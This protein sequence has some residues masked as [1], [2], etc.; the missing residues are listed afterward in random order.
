METHIKVISW[1]YIILGA[2]GLLGAAILILLVA[3]GGLISGDRT[4]ILATT[5]VS[6][7][8]GTVIILVSVPGIIAGIGLLKYRPWARILALVLGILNLPGFPVGTILGIYTI[9][10]LLDDESAG[11]FESSV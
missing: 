11:L 3:G 7:I 6:V 8:L 2:L 9:W 5:L 1:L 10:A 4:A